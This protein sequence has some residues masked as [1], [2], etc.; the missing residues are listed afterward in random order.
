MLRLAQLFRHPVKGIGVETLDRASVTQGR[1]LPLDRAWALAHEAAKPGTG[2]RNC[3][4]FIRGA[5]SPA[6][7]A[8][9]VTSDGAILTFRH[10]DRPALRV[11]PDADP[12]ALIDWVRPLCNPGR[13]APSDL[14]K[15]DGTA[16]TDSDYPSISILNLASL[17]ALS[18]KA[19]QPLDPRR[20]RSNLWFDG[21]GPWQEF[22][23][24]GQTI[25][26]AGIPFEVT[27]RITRCTATMAS[28]ESGKVDVDT[29]RLL[30]DGW[31]H[32]DFGVYAIARGDGTIRIGDEVT[33]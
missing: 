1:C 30:Q 3:A 11:D 9:T 18:D 28:P 7:M 25:H 15:V 27:E 14:V 17:R 21:G 2:W 8:V 20:F 6:L 16:M 4:N 26:V 12:Q 5:K 19:G 33:E 23:W 31:G 13:A 10:P 22:E 29:L 24:I 32:R